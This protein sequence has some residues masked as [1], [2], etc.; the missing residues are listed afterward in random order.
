MEHG[1]IQL[2]ENRA[3]NRGGPDFKV[4]PKAA[5]ELARD[6]EQV[7]MTSQRREQ[8]RRLKEEL[9]VVEVVSPSSPMITSIA[10]TSSPVCQA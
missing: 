10:I 9:V 6:G 8:V 5:R 3:L 1:G 7:A 4:A 2:K